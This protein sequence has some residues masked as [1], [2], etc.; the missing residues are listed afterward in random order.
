MYGAILLNDNNEILHTF[1]TKTFY[2][3]LINSNNFFINK[4]EKNNVLSSSSTSGI[5]S[6]LIDSFES[7]E[8]KPNNH[9]NFTQTY[10]SNLK[11]QTNFLI[12]INENLVKR[13]FFLKKKF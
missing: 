6:T 2:Y 3:Q 13:A 12:E 8:K 1:G 5:S 11:L 9:L 7:I 10:L 4:K